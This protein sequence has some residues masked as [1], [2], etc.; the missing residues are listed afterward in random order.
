M[1]IDPDRLANIKLA[2]MER[3]GKT[4]EDWENFRP[5]TPP[6]PNYGETQHSIFFDNPNDIHFEHPLC[7]TYEEVGKRTQRTADFY[8]AKAKALASESPVQSR[9]YREDAIVYQRIADV[10]F[11][12]ADDVNRKGR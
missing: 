5:A 9:Y 4:E 1:A 10:M 3:Y 8:L 2:W 7:P 11:A 12:N 6:R